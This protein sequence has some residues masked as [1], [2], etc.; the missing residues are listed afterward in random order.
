VALDAKLRE[1]LLRSADFCLRSVVAV[2]NYPL[3]N[4]LLEEMFVQP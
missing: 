3:L 1:L 4:A 2:E